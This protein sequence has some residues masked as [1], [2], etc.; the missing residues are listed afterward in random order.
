MPISADPRPWPVLRLRI[1]TPRAN[2]CVM[3][4]STNAHRAKQIT[5]PNFLLTMANVRSR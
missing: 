2:S 1:A 4:A 5:G 3:L